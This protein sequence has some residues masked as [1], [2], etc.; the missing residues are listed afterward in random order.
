VLTW[1]SDASPAPDSALTMTMTKPQLLALLAGK[2]TDGITM[3]GDGSQLA[4]L[5][6]VL[7]TPD[8]RLPVVTPA[9]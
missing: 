7:D 5:L 8:R 4:Q 3:T 6:A 1:T 9:S 2:G